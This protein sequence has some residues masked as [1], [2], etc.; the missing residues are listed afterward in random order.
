M[1]I[2][3]YMDLFGIHFHFYIGN[4]RKLYTSYGGIISLICIFCCILI[5]FILTFK[6]ISH[7]NPISNVSSIS[8]AG[9]HKVT[10]KDE[11][12]WIPWRIIDFK[13][14]FINHTNILYPTIY[15]KKGEKDNIEKKFTFKTQ[16]IN[17]TLCNET[18]FANRGKNHFI[19]VALDELYCIEFDNIELG[20]GWNADFLNYL[21]LDIYICKDGIE[22]DKNNTNCTKIENLKEF[23][24]KNDTWVFEYFYP[25][26]EYQPTNYENPILVIYKNHLYNFS[27]HLN[28]DERMYVQEY[29]LNDDKGLVFNDDKNFSFWGYFSSDFDILFSNGDLLNEKHSSKLYSLSVYLDAGKIL[30]T[31]RFNKIYTVVANVFPLFNLVFFIFD[32]FSYMIKTIMT[33]KYLSELFFQRINENDKINIDKDKRKSAGF[34]YHKLNISKNDSMLKNK[35]YK[36]NKENNRVYNERGKKSNNNNDFS[37]RYNDSNN[38]E[39]YKNNF[40]N[41]SNINNNEENNIEKNNNNNYD[42]SNT[43][44]IF[45]KKIQNLNKENISKNSSNETNTNKSNLEKFNNKFKKLLT[46]RNTSKNNNNNSSF[47]CINSPKHNNFLDVNLKKRNNGNKDNIKN[48]RKEKNVNNKLIKND[49]INNNDYNNND[50]IN[51]NNNEINESLEKRNNY[52]HFNFYKNRGLNNSAIITRFRLKGSLFKMKDYIYSFFI[53]AVRKEYKYLSKEFAAIFNFLSD[54][55]DISSYLQLYRQFHIL[56]GFLLDNVANIDLNHKININNK[57]LFEQIALK[58]KNIFYFALKEQFR[59]ISNK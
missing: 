58:N 22:Y 2:L 28:K 39:N 36:T 8:Q 18:D 45:V 24:F 38:K 6:E 34:F 16:I 3:K 55:Y 10:F 13:Q 25:I 47:Y 32:S 30:Y 48:N 53:K 35:E 40:S 9:Y 12:I 5:F 11:K 50:N 42:Y 26:V 27:S 21:Q 46:N 29:I 19:D 37:C 52:S 33:E 7:K 41:N 57:E 49:I 59:Q 51:D 17:Y 44:N 14:K 43:R 20:G 54:I 1:K 15:I 31:R 23:Y 4:K 56:S